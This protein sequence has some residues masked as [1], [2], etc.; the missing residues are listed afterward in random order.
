MTNCL[1]NKK[2][3]LQTHEI[4]RECNCKRFKC[5]E[6]IPVMAKQNIIN[7]FNSFQSVSEQNSH[8]CGLINIVPVAQRRPRKPEEE[9][10]LRD[11]AVGYKVR[12]TMDNTITE[13]TICRQ[14]F[15]ALHGITKS[16]VEY[17][18]KSL[19]C[20]GVSPRD[21]RGCHTNRPRKL[22]Q[23]NTELVKNHIAS[24]KGRTSHYS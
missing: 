2:L 9:A 15:I 6:E 24:L 20:T 23:E 4:G 5:A 13:R 18:V 21:R 12:C 3:R 16:N 17:L 22:T 11:C 8:L 1:V 7:H 19:K 10:S 14:E